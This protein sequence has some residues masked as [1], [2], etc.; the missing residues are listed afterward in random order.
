MVTVVT[1]QC[2]QSGGQCTTQHTS[3]SR[4]DPPTCRLSCGERQEFIVARVHDTPITVTTRR[5]ASDGG[6]RQAPSPGPAPVSRIKRSFPLDNACASGRRPQL[7][8]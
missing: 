2:C 7:Q 8:I 5:G 6:W 4:D 1:T 3:A